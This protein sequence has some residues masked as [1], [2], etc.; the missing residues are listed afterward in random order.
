M[1]EN[2]PILY[3]PDENKDKKISNK[4]HCKDYLDL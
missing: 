1:I 3:C 2:L 4:K